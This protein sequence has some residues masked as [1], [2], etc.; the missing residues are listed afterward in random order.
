MTIDSALPNSST[1]IPT[2]GIDRRQLIK[3]G[4]W[5]APVL[6]AAVA[7]PAAVAS[8]ALTKAAITAG[9]P[10]VGGGRGTAVINYASVFYAYG[11]WGL[12]GQNSQTAGPQS[13][14]VRWRVA[15]KKADGTL[16]AYFPIGAAP[17]L[18]AKTSTIA[19]Y[20][21]ASVAGITLTGVPAGAYTA[22]TEV[23]SVSYTPNPIGGVTFATAA[24]SSLP[25]SVTVT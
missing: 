21:T 23:V 25:R 14:S 17:D 15:L 2:R 24:F 11:E 5:A 12:K 16:Y 19:K 20:G 4:A 9:K 6:I 7:V 13:A 1:D 18:T 3:A 8:S 10:G 22:V